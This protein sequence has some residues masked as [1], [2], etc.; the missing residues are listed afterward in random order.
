[1]RAHPAVAVER[2][3][4][5]AFARCSARSTWTA[6]PA[7]IPTAKEEMRCHAENAIESDGAS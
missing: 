3:G 7:P 4:R 1:M 6:S 2:D 5:I